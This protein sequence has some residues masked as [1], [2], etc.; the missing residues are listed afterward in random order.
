MLKLSLLQR[1]SEILYMFIIMLVKQFSNIEE[2]VVYVL[3]IVIHIIC[4]IKLYAFIF[5]RKI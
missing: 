4:T 1:L 3:Q 5:Y 2:Y